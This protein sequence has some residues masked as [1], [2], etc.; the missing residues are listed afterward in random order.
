MN[1]STVTTNPLT[2]STVSIFWFNRE[3]INPYG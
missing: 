3:A 2:I 1:P